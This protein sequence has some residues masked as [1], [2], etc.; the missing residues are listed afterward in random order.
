MSSIFFSL[1]NVDPALSSF[2]E[3][4]SVPAPITYLVC[5]YGMYM[6]GKGMSPLHNYRHLTP[7]HIVEAHGFSEELSSSP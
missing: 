3:S 6:I 2:A 5:I 4:S 7:S 1:S